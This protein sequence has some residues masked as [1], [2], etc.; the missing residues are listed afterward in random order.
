MGLVDEGDGWD[1]P[2]YVS[3]KVYLMEHMEYSQLINSYTN[4]DGHRA[5]EL[6]SLRLPKEW[7]IESEDQ[8]LARTIVEACL[9]KSFGF[10]LAHGMILKLTGETLGSFWRANDGCDI[11][12]W[13]YAHWL[14]YGITYWTQ[15]GLPP[16]LDFQA[17][18]PNK[19]GS[20]LEE[21]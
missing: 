18:L 7:E 12:P 5:F 20:L 10:K 6:M 13:T 9:Q 11:M 3:N 8:K 1:G 15:N 14:R 19:T 2:K 16:P 21:A 4:S 17:I